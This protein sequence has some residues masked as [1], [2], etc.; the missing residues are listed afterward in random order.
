MT[1]QKDN[2]CNSK[3]TK[4]YKNFFNNKKN[5]Y[6]KSHQGLYLSSIGMGMYKGD[7]FTDYEKL[8]KMSLKNGINVFDTAR[9]YRF[10]LSE[11]QLGKALNKIFKQKNF[12]RGCIFISSKAGLI[13]FPKKVRPKNYINEILIKKRGIRATSIINN[14]ACYDKKFI[15]QEIEI[16]LKKTNLKMIDNYYLHNP[17]FLLHK[18]KGNY[19]EF[20]KL[21]ELLEKKC[22]DKK[23][24]SYGISSW[25]GFRRYGNS[26]FYINLKKIIEISLD[27]AGSRNNFKNLQ[28]PL[29]VCMPFILND[30]KKNFLEFLY[31]KKINLF[32]SGSLYEGNIKSFFN[33]YKYLNNSLNKKDCE[34]DL[35]KNEK[36][37]PISDDTFGQMFSDLI[38]LKKNN[39]RVEKFFPDINRKNDLYL[40]S[41]NIVRSTD[42]VTTSLCGME[43]KEYLENFLKIK[44]LN[45]FKSKEYWKFYK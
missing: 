33:M 18:N 45:K 23:I 37:I 36:S 2:Y 7:K 38:K 11:L 6:N 39:F 32:T 3:D 9:K 44:K 35:E 8:V 40:K 22:L 25:A 31:E 27:V 28:I 19:K 30:Y 26:N 24:K 15:E 16:S 5:F 13:C 4:F 41:L 10:G 42:Y 20:Y 43:K 1:I 34:N 12:K 21:F 14:F 29:N 17:E